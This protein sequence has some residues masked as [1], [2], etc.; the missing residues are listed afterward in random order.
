MLKEN[1]ARS[2]YQ[3]FAPHSEPESS[4]VLY[5]T[6]SFRSFFACRIPDTGI[7]DR[8]SNTFLPSAGN[9]RKDQ[10]LLYLSNTNYSVAVISYYLLSDATS[11]IGFAFSWRIFGEKGRLKLELLLFI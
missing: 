4:Y 7:A 11:H 3:Q 10:V 6:I 5:K 9:D 8:R 2:C 1:I